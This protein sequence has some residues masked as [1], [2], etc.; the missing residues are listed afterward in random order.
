[1]LAMANKNGFVFASIPGLANRARVDIE[2]AREAIQKFQQPDPDSRTK[3]FEGRRI[4]EVDGGWRLLNYA[5]HRAIRDEEERREYMKNLMRKKRS[6]SNVSRSNPSLS[7]AEAE[8]EAEAEAVKSKPSSRSASTDSLFEKAYEQYPR[9]VGK[10]AA[11]KA[12]PKAIA[13]SESEDFLYQRVMTYAAVCER[14]GKEK[15]FI[16]HMATWLNRGSFMDDPTEWAV[17]ANGNGVGKTRH[18]E[19]MDGIEKAAARILAEIDAGD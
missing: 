6:V 13:R 12:W 10:D 3:D 2:S 14:T 15:Q 1:M 11:K 5:K 19:D 9:H 4:E 18:Q 17:Q 8:A 16:P 7:Q